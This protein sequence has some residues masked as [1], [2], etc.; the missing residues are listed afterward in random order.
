[1]TLKS[2]FIVKIMFGK[3]YMFFFVSYNYSLH[4]IVIPTCG[5]KSK[6]IKWI[7]F[8]LLISLFS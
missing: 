8:Q 6:T 1:M 7:T 5:H 3:D 4:S 2:N